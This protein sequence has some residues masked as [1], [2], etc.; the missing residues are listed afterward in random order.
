M[1]AAF[2]RALDAHQLAELIDEAT[3]ELLRRA[4]ATNETVL[5]VAA[6]Y[7]ITPDRLTGLGRDAQVVAARREV[8]RR[9]RAAGANLKEIGA[10]IR[11]DRTT[12][13]H[14]LRATRRAEQ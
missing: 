14:N 6:E 4:P 10:A 2:V 12:V 7:S 3:T 1:I 13:M 5:A 11:R 8:I 9:L